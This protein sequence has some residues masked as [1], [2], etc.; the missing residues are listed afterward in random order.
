MASGRMPNSGLPLKF[1]EKKHIG[2]PKNPKFAQKS[3]VDREAGKRFPLLP[4][5]FK[6]GATGTE[7]PFHHSI[8]SNFMLYQDRL[9]N[10][11][12]EAIR[13]PRKFRIVLCNFCYYF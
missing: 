6:S 2:S 1:F 5:L 11:F 8:V 10:T 9:N 4:C 13:A 12:V 7:M 3:Q